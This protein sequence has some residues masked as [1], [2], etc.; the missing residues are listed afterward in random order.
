[1][2][3]SAVGYD[4]SSSASEQS[5]KRVKASKMSLKNIFA[6]QIDLTARYCDNEPTTSKNNEVLFS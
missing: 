3:T 1:M 6:R 4:S 5:N 2:E